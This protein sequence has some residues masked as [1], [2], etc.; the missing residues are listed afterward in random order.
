L[1]LGLEVT[2][3]GPGRAEAGTRNAA[4]QCRCNFKLTRHRRHGASA[5]STVAAASK[6]KSFCSQTQRLRALSYSNPSQLNRHS[7]SGPQAASARQVKNR[8]RDHP[9]RVMTRMIQSTARLAAAIMIAAERPRP[10]PIH[11]H[12]SRHGDSGS[13]QS[14]WE[15]DGPEPGAA[16]AGPGE[17]SA[18]RPSPPG[19][20]ASRPLRLQGTDSESEL[21]TPSHWQTRN[22][23]G[24]IRVT[25]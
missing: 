25:Y 20:A 12:A 9:G 6:S 10:P 19:A 11:D 16:A 22:C 2:G 7:G 18:A 13:C 24:L 17:I 4:S 8:I 1:T 3:A 15:S 5:A 23:H 14:A 21:R